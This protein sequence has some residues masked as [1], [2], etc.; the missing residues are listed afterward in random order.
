MNNFTQTRIQYNSATQSTS[1]SCIDHLY[2]NSKHRISGVNIISFGSSDHDAVAYTRFSRD[3]SPPPRTIRKRSYKHFKE[4]EYLEDISKLDFTDVYRSQDVDVA[5]DLL[6]A[7]LVNVL[8][9]HAPWIIFQ[10]R[11]KFVPW[12]TSETVKLMAE[13]DRYK[14]EAKA[15][16]ISGNGD[17]AHLWG[18]YKKLRNKINNRIKQ[19]EVLYK[20]NKVAECQD[21]PSRLWGIAKKFMDYA[22]PGPPAQLEVEIDKK[23]TLYTKSRDLAR[24]MNEY[25]IEKV[26][27]I[28]EGLRNVPEDLSGCI[29]VMAGRKLSLSSK[30]VTVKKVE[31]LLLS[32]KNKTS[33]SMDQ[34]DNYAV[35]LAA[36]HI[37]GPLHHVITL[38]VLQEKFPTSWKY[39]KIVPLHKKKSPLKRENYRPVAIL[40]PLSKVLEKI[41]YEHIYNYF[42]RNNLFHPSL[43]GYR[44]G[45]STMTALLSMYDKWVQAATKGQVS[46]VVLVDLSAAF[47]LVSPALLVKKLKIYGLEEDI[48]TWITSYLTDRYQSVWIDHTYSGLIENSIGVPQGSNLGPLFFLIFFNDLPTNI[49]EQLDCFADDSTMGASAASVTEISTRLDKECDNLSCWMQ[50]NRFKLNAEKTHLMTVGTSTRLWQLQDKLEVRMEGIRLSESVDRCEGLLGVTVQCDLKWSQHI[51]VLTSKLK[52]RLTGLEKLKYVMTKAS[53]NKIVQGVFNSVL[54]YCIPLYGGCNKSELH[55]L[56]VQQNRAARC[57]LRLPPGSNR[58]FIFKKLG[59]FTVRQLIAYHTLIAVY[60]IRTNRQPEYL[61]NI[62]TRDNMYGNIIVQNSSLELFRNSFTYRGSVLWN[63]LPKHTRKEI[64]IGTFKK[65]IKTWIVENVPR[66]DD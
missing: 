66:F 65:R 10:E 44:R 23:I 5:A 13:R 46:G 47:D 62:L 4:A 22:S 37:A 7:K 19:E 48:T 55:Q 11:K 32:L 39:T 6:T 34:L 61:A 50:A 9:L 30:F 21:S 18:K 15:L 42:D 25:F 40:S 31:S 28:V 14:E 16:S 56:Q 35:K 57:V 27:K 36:H 45:R 24:I 64:K 29:K 59:W 2:C 17:T 63:R 1:S 53:R 51:G 54:C 58:D 41:F 52:S 3:P 20:K 12:L 38:S 8:N 60:R 49:E 43:H 33:T 26:K